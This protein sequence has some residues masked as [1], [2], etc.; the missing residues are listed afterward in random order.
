MSVNLLQIIPTPPHSSDGIGDYGL[1]LAEQLFKHDRI[2]TEFL[3][4]R[5]D[6]PVEP[7]IHGFPMIRLPEHSVSAFLQALPEEI[8]GIILQYSNYPYV[9]TNLRGLLQAPFWFVEALQQ[10]IQQRQLKL[11]VMF[12]ELP[13]FTWRQFHLN[14]LNPIQSLV[15]RRLAEMATQ[16]LT[17]SAQYQTVLS[18]W[19]KQPVTRVA[20]FSNM[21]EPE[22]VPSL[23]ARDRRLVV[24]GGASRDRVYQNALKDLIHACQQLE[25]TEIYDVGPALNLQERYA[26]ESPSL[27]ELG[28]RS[29]SE[30][31]ELLLT[32]IAGCLDYT[33]FPGD[34][35]KS[36]VLAAYCAHG[37]VPFV[38]QYNPS[39]ADGLFVNQHYIALNQFPEALNEHQIQ[40]VASSAHTWYKSHSLS[41]VAKVFA[42][43]FLPKITQGSPV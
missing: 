33:P 41:E 43:Q 37:V 34:L 2:R 22:C 32:S 20:I 9:N 36:G 26:F 8:D 16:V 6:V 28:F 15:S 23:A 18:N 3:I 12:H 5:T 24:F 1:L 27:R 42:A 19:T 10:A 11:I 25:I 21:G 35:S 38:T 40:A 30:I 17:N 39:E 7:E 31:S 14:W 29:P 13:R 4:F